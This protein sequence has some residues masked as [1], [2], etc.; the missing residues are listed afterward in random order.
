MQISTDIDDNFFILFACCI[1]VKGAK[2]SI[3]CDVQRREYI[4]IPNAL[5][6]I[7]TEYKDRSIGW[8]K[9]QFDTK[10]Q[11]IISAYFDQLIERE[12]GFISPSYKEFPKLNLNPLNDPKIISNAIVDYSEESN[13]DIHDIIDQLS[14]FFCDALEIRFFCLKPIQFIQE[15]VSATEHSSLRYLQ[16]LL[17]DSDELNESFLLDLMDKS[18]RLRTI[19]VH[20]SRENKTVEEK[21]FLIYYTTEIIDT[22]DCC[23]NCSPFYFSINYNTFI[24]AQKFNSCLNRKISVDSNGNIKNCPSMKKSYGKVKDKL[25]QEVVTDKD[26]RA[27]WSINKNEIEVCRDCEYRYICQDCRAYTMDDQSIYSKPSKCTYDPYSD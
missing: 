5:Y 8:I 25:L 24:E 6:I 2:R 4:K 15:I 1:P 27:I 7:L 11:Q 17:K 19:T 23:G 10:G 18:P 9:N 26:F 21:D 22:E 13:H 16:L 12:Y 20:S 14:V 3:I